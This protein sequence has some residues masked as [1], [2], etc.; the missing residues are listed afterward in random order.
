MTFANCIT[1]SR[2][3]LT[4]VIG[5]FFYASFPGSKIWSFGLYVLTATTDW[6]D[7]WVAR[8]YHQISDFG[9][10]MDALNDKI[11]IIA[12]FIL[13]SGKS[14]IPPWGIFCVM[15]I[16]CREFFITGLRIL[17]A[18]SGIIMAAAKMGK[19]KTIL[20]FIVVGSYFFLAMVRADGT[21][22]WV[23]S[24]VSLLE[25]I[26]TF[27]FVLATVLTLHSGFY[28]VHKYAAYLR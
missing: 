1:L 15:I 11:F 16:I 19:L 20:Q 17:L 7:G 28:Y 24:Y 9:K 3:P 4:F 22:M 10:L 27:N 14:L 5:L 2:I 18:K 21:P 6:I 25:G 12:M 23:Q 26:N 8:K 13:L